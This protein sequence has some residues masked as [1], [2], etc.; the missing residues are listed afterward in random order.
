MHKGKPA[1]ARRASTVTCSIFRTLIFTA[2]LASPCAASAD[3]R[4]IFVA[5]SVQATG[6]ARAAYV[7]VSQADR[8]LG[9]SSAV[10]I[11]GS[12]AGELFVVGRV[13]AQHADSG[14]LSMLATVELQDG[15]VASSAW[16]VDASSKPDLSMLSVNELRARV[17]AARSVSE[18]TGGAVT[19][20]PAMSELLKF[21]RVLG[22]DTLPADAEAHRQRLADLREITKQRLAALSSQPAPAAFRKRQKDLAEQLNAITLALKAEEARRRESGM[23]VSPELQEKLDLIESTKDEHI[24]L[25]R[26]ELM[27]LRR[28]R[29]AE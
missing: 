24:D 9:V 1:R 6:E 27:E 7:A 18:R 16:E 26:K 29:G 5:H 25:L 28:E 10:T 3:G 19:R 22:G 4:S 21:E 13:L 17:A 15:S 14:T 8:L 12:K 20:S 23:A 2:A 11:P